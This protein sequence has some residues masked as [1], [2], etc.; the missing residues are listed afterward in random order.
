MRTPPAVSLPLADDLA[1]RAVHAALCS[2]A[3]CSLLAWLMQR[4]AWA[5]PL[6]ISVLVLCGALAAALG[7]WLSR[8]QPSRLAWTGAQ[9]QWSLADSAHVLAAAPDVML[10]FGPWM[11]LRLRLAPNGARRWVT[12][13]PAGDAPRWTAFRAAVYSPASRPLGQSST[14]LPRS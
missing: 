2:L 14:D 10:D 11:L 3:A 9:W 7:W 4:A 6:S 12:A 5:I 13:R 8:Q 1:W